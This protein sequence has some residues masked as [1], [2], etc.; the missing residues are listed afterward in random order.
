MP[1]SSTAFLETLASVLLRCWIINMLLLLFSCAIFISTGDLIDRVHGRT[2]GLT[3]HELDLIIYCGLAL[4]KI[5]VIV[6]F[7]IPWLSIR[8]VVRKAEQ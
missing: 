7:F 8:L 3:P 2:F 6:L 1:G 4:H 5:M